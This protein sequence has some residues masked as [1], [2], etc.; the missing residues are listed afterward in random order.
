[1]NVTPHHR[2]PGRDFGFETE[3]C[4]IQAPDFKAS[5]TCLK[6]YQFGNILWSTTA[7]AV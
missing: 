6:T 7:N 3:S 1:M 4:D 5:Y 2:K